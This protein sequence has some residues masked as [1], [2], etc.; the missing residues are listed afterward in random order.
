MKVGLKQGYV[1]SSLLF[2]I[3]LGDAVEEFRG[4]VKYGGILEDEDHK[5]CGILISL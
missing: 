2:S 1:F 4:T 5:T 3:L